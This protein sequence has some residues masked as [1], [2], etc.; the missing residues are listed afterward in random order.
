MSA[1]KHSAELDE[2]KLAYALE[3]LTHAGI[4]AGIVERVLTVMQFGKIKPQDML[5]YIESARVD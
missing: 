3:L 4:A 5:D 1:P 2:E